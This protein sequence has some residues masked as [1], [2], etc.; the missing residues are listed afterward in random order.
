MSQS[1]SLRLALVQQAAGDDVAANAKRAEEGVRLA[2]ERGARLVCLP[3]LFRTRYFP[4]VESAEPFA[5]AEAI[6]GPTTERM[7]AVARELGVVLVVPVFERRAAGLY[8]NSAA[9]IDADGRLVG[10]YR[11]M[12]VP[13]DPLFFEKFYFTPGDLGFSA[14]DTAAGRIGVLICWDQWF[15]EAARLLALDGAQLLL[16]PTAI[17]WLD[18]DSPEEN[19]ASRD[20]WVTVQRAH[21]IANGVFV[22]AANRTGR[23]DRLEFYGGSF[24][25]DPDGRVLAQASDAEDVLIVDC[26]LARVERQRQAWPFLRDRR[27]D[28]YGPLLERYRR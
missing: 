5:L 15:P 3:E 16:Y 20:A 7:A 22:A 19:R 13:D 14:F 4:Q 21:A 25:C 10:T 11:K 26:D 8:H 23:E 12:H 2:A 18:S 1:R 24:A 6:P 9:V 28:A 17:A 27:V